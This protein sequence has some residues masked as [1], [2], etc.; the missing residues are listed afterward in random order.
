MNEWKELKIDNLP[1]DIL[2]GD[3]EF[4]FYNGDTWHE[5]PYWNY[6]SFQGRQM[7]KL[8][9]GTREYRYRLRPHKKT[10]EEMAEEY[11]TEKVFSS[12]VLRALVRNAFR[13]GYKAREAELDK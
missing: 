12:P 6:P 3:Y 9:D 1:P 10:I 11:L 5:A 4:E 7:Q 13:A 8:I 2:M